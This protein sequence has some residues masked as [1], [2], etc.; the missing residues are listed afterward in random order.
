MTM[1]YNPA[2]NM[3]TKPV[4]KL[5]RKDDAAQ[6]VEVFADKDYAVA[7]AYMLANG[8]AIELLL[9]KVEVMI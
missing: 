9:K 8:G 4:Y 5:Y 1:R 7:E 6:W 3:K 2:V